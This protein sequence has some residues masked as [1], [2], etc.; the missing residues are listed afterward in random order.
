MKVDHISFALFA[1]RCLYK[2]S[3]TKRFIFNDDSSFVN[4]LLLLILCSDG[5]YVCKS[6]HS[7]I[8]KNKA[9]CHTVAD[10]LLVE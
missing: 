1:I 3:F 2:R 9:P 10:K 8:K 4:S 7:K 6:C 5:V